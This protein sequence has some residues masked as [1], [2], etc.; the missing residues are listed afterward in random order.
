MAVLDSHEKKET[1][2]SFNVH[3]NGNV[4]CVRPAVR[5]AQEIG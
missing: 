3:L 1:W 4:S 2:T 5:A